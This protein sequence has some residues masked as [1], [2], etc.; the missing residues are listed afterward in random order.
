MSQQCCLR[1]R[2]E[3]SA[4]STTILSGFNLIPRS[5]SCLRFEPAITDTLVRLGYSLPAGFER[6]AFHPLGK[7]A[8]FRTHARILHELPELSVDF[9]SAAWLIVCRSMVIAMVQ[10]GSAGMCREIRRQTGSGTLWY[11]LANLIYPNM[12]VKFLNN[13]VKSSETHA[14][15]GLGHQLTVI[16]PRRWCRLTFQTKNITKST[17]LRSE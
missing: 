14:I 5:S 13:Q 12:P 4:P 17:V 16:R 8:A 2:A 7:H 15:C 3:P 6:R 1:V 11:F 9:T 10:A